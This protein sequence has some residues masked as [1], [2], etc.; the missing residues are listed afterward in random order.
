VNDARTGL[1]CVGQ[2]WDGVGAQVDFT[3]P[4][5]VAWWQEG[6]RTQVLDYG[7]DAGWNDNNEYEIWDDFG[8]SNGF[9]RAIPIER[10]RPL[11]PLLMTRATAE[12]QARYRPGERVYTVTRAGPPGIQR[13][14][15]TWSGDNTTSWH[16][17]RWNIRMGL[18]M[19]LSG[20]YNTGH[21]VGGFFGPVPEPELL[22]RW[23][24][25]GAFSPRF[26]MN[27]WKAGGEVNTP[28]LHRRA[29]PAIRDAIRLRYRLMPYLYT[30]YRAAAVDGVPI[31]RPTFYEFDADPQAFADCDDFML[32]PSLLVACVVEPGQ[33]RRRVYLPRGP[34]GWTDFWTGRRYAP[35]TEVEVDAPL[36]RVP[37]LVP[38][39]GMLAL[40]DTLDFSRLHDEPT[41]QLRVFPAPGAARS[42]FTLYEDDGLSRDYRQG[43]MA[44]T[45]FELAT[46]SRTIALT[47]RKTGRYAL[48][49]DAV[50]IVLPPTERRRVTLR[51]EG[52]HLG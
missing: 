39:G 18:G 37:L 9:G 38:D 48:P 1:P 23:A 13:H 7:I 33:R 3:H 44:E 40:T 5:G 12:E 4:A 52:V 19:S 17:L 27:S 42:A 34:S 25:N 15:Q 8:A 28:W 32:G 29:L 31:L 21:D 43:M 22:I 36:E 16:N 11:Q 47:A 49:Y 26:I 10:S 50:R 24:Q 6:L 51:G 41:R 2:F 45:A 14:A 20:M 30:L 46:T 35:G